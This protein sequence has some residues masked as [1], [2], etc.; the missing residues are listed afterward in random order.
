VIIL[1]YFFVYEA[2]FIVYEPHFIVCD[3]RRNIRVVSVDFIV[4]DLFYCLY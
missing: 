1:T 3:F 2:Y 4:Y